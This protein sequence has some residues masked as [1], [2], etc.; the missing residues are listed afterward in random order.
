MLIEEDESHIV[1]ESCK[2]A[3]HVH[4]LINAGVGLAAVWT[5]HTNEVIPCLHNRLRVGFDPEGHSF[6]RLW[7]HYRR[8]HGILPVIQK[9]TIASVHGSRRKGERAP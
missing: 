4:F 9:T 2:C 8:A 7:A 3:L 6:A 1:L 5:P